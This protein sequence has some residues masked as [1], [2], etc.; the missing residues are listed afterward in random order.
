M[1]FDTPAEF[2]LAGDS[3]AIEGYASVFG[4]VDRGGDVI[5]PGAF[6]KF[7]KTRDDK[8]LLLYQHDP[9]SPIGK[10][11]VAQDSTGLHFK[12]RLVLSD[13]TA[14]RA[15][16]HMKEGLLDGM[17]IGYDVLPGGAKYKDDRRELTAIH[18]HEI[19]AVTW[20]MNPLAHVDVVKSA[21]DCADVRELEQLVREQLGLSSR[22]AKAV[23]SR[24]WPLVAD[25]EDRDNDREDRGAESLGALAAELQKLNSFLTKG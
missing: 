20:G 18:L 16:N 4:N 2:K 22:K 19:S 11:D 6:Q 8:V 5:L 1:Y 10:A 3:G 14:K 25:R 21:M 12:A 13:P 7:S 15:Y 24:C 23:A 17:S 9:R